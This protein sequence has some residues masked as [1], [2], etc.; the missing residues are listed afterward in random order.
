M[1]KQ[2]R[3]R[4]NPIGPKDISERLILVIRMVMLMRR[5]AYHVK[6]LAEVID[7]PIRK[8]Y[9]LMNSI[10]AAELPLKT[11]DRGRYYIDK[12]RWKTASKSA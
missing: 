4:I 9:R 5:R 11:N 7:T 8:T 10:A 1:N 6:E 3:P 12:K 2:G